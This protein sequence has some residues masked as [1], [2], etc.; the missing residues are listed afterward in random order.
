M[1]F[2]VFK[3]LNSLQTL[4]LCAFMSSNK[5]RFTRRHCYSSHESAQLHNKPSSLLCHTML[6]KRQRPPLSLSLSGLGSGLTFTPLTAGSGLFHDQ[7]AVFRHW[8]AF[9]LFAV[10]FPI[11]QD[12]NASLGI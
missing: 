12:T 4:Q 6:N 11:L 7:S 1:T 3:E 8:L 2:D 9:L 10:R 5:C